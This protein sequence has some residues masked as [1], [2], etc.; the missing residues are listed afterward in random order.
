[1][2]TCLPKTETGFRG[3]SQHRIPVG[4][5]FYLLSPRAQPASLFIRTGGGMAMVNTLPLACL[6][7]T[8]TECMLT[9]AWL[10]PPHPFIPAFPSTPDFM[11][12][13]WPVPPWF[14]GA[15]VGRTTS[16]GNTAF[17][18]LCIFCSM[19]HADLAKHVAKCS[20]DRR[21]LCRLGFEACCLCAQTWSRIHHTAA[22]PFAC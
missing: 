13:E 2:C 6:Y 22:Q 15:L 11:L 4:P 7:H 21:R 18:G 20:S 14:P 10:W 3:L 17:P 8:P 9:S 12:S 5:A 1:M 19:Q 16:S